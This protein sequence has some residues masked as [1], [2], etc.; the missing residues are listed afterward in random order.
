[1]QLSVRDL[2]NLLNVAES[3]VTRWIRERGLPARRAGNHYRV[4]RAELLAWATANHVRVSQ[5]LFDH[6]DA[7]AVSDTPLAEALERGGI[8]HHLPGADKRDA[9]R[10]LV[11]V[12]ELPAGLDRELLVHLFRAREA[13]ASTAVG[14]GIAI[15]HVRHPIVLHVPQPAVTLAFLESPVDFGAVDGKPVHVL[16][17]IISPTNRGHLQLLSRLTFGLHDARF[18]EA[19]VRRSPR[20]KILSELRR[21]EGLMS[22]SA[23]EPGRVGL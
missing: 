13:A 20:D 22:V 12:L 6:L 19:V 7:Q 21:V 5:L 1:M 8:H 4:N 2:T 16:F 10:A 17:S 18:R 3:T 14:D 23:S 9:L 15:P 11:Q